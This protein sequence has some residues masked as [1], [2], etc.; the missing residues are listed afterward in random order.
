MK[1]DYQVRR[2]SAF[3]KQV[4]HKDIIMQTFENM[5]EAQDYSIKL[6]A[7]YNTRYYVY[8]SYK[9]EYTENKEYILP[10]SN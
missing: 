9:P 8:I 1:R 7:L 10:C 2:Y 4:L 5:R 3:P 6:N